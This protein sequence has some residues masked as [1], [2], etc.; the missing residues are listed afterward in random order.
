M[1]IDDMDEQKKVLI[2]GL[3]E[4]LESA[5]EDEAKNRVKSAITMYFKTLVESCDFLIFN[6]ILKVPSNHNERFRI[7][8]K[9][10]P[11][12]YKEAD[13]LFNIY[14]K[15]YSKK[16]DK[17]DMVRVKNGTL[18]IIKKTGIGE[19]IPKNTKK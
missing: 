17:E 10:F 6:K 13:Y 5:K 19:Y 8:E 14:R 2:E 15:T 7:L 1:S 18:G 3:V 11:E 12:I 16:V 9:Y 4:F